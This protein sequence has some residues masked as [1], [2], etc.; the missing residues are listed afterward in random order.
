MT[1]AADLLAG[2]RAWR[3]TQA[4]PVPGVPGASQAPGT[5]GEAQKSA[6]VP[7]VPAVP[8]DNEE[9]CTHRA[10]ADPAEA[11]VAFYARFQAAA[12]LA[13]PDEDLAAERAVMALHY[14]APAE[15]QPCQPGAP[16]PLHDGLLAG[17]RSHRRTA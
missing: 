9:G 14:A 1:A 8:G 4:E 11:R 2:W 16:D 13:A 5:A 6:I 17:W 15:A 3:A 12:A 10:P 7:G